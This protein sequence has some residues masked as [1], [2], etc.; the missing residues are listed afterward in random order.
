MRGVGRVHAAVTL[1]AVGLAFSVARPASAV[2]QAYLVGPGSQFTPAGGQAEA[3]TG[4]FELEQVLFEFRFLALGLTGDNL[5][6]TLT[7]KV[8]IPGL[9]ELALPELE[10]DAP[11]LPDIDSLVVERTTLVPQSAGEL[12]YR[13]L[14]LRTSSAGSPDNQVTFDPNFS[15]FIPSAIALD[16]ELIEIVRVSLSGQVSEVSTTTLG[17]MSLTATPVPEPGAAVLFGAGLALLAARYRGVGSRSS[18]AHRSR[19]PGA[20]HQSRAIATYS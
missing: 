1:L 18:A 16:L 20:R 11:D 7:P 4:G 3:I 5:D 10:I 6:L 2:S 17:T 14:A 12:R 8:A 13:D 19:Q 9:N 15:N